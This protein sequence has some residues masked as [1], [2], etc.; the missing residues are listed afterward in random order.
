MFF[1]QLIN[2]MYSINTKTSP[3]PESLYLWGSGQHN[4]ILYTINSI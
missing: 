1:L 3:D 2:N 4:M